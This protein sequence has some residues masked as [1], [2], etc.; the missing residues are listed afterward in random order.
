MSSDTSPFG[1]G[2]FVPGFDFLQKLSEGAASALPGM[3]PL[4]GWVAPTMSLPEIDQRIRELKTVQFWLEQNAS[5][6]T[7]TIQ[8]LQVQRMTLATLQGMNVAMSDLARGAF[9]AGGAPSTPEPAPVPEA[10][11]APA[12]Q[13]T[14]Q[15][16]AAATAAAQP[17]AAAPGQPGVDPLQW[18][19][20]LTQQFQQLASQAMG[21]AS[22]QQAALEAS[23]QMTAG[24]VKAAQDM[25]SSLTA[26]P[27]GK[28]AAT[29]R[30]RAV[31]SKAAP[32]KA[33]RKSGGKSGK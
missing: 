6:L 30:K 33:A 10:A 32:A 4:A 14:Q 16:S 27:A 24:A 28:K 15:G 19:G 13:A 29:A 21:D 20:A 18:W 9:A 11:P 1:F 26:A 25:A 3:P 23:R 7:A 2:R 17:D 31:T 8:A 12:A 5:A 22:A